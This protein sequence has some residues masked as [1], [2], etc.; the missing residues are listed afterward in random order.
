MKTPLKYFVKNHYLINKLL[1]PILKLRSDYINL[2]VNRLDK[3][4]GQIFSN[5]EIGS[6]V[7][8]LN[9]IPGKYEID[10]RSHI[11]RRI[12]ITKEYE[13]SIVSLIR[14]NITPNKDA[15]NIGA[16]IG[17]F[18]SFMA[19]NINEDR[20]VLAIEPTPNAYKFLKDNVERNGNNNKVIIYNGI[21]T[22]KFGDYKINVIQ[23]K[24]EYASIGNIVIPFKEQQKSISI[25]V[26]GE[27]VDNLV[28]KFNLTPGIIVI[29]VE[30]AEY[31]VLKGSIDTIKKH[32]PV[33]I[34]EIEDKYLFEQESNS[35]QIIE[36]LEGLGYRVVN[37]DNARI[38]FPFSGNIIAIPNNIS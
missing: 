18:T 22:D 32:M 11:L 6:I 23:G 10:V 8:T 15:I 36:L 33:I 14:K 31:L 38:K 28:R 13:P 4:F 17:L 35:K 9:N 25:D 34:S 24:E 16:N 29:D 1:F 27:T 20:K 3:Y 5:V 7:V 19:D 37:C 30:G 26:K 2:Y 21:A 12:L